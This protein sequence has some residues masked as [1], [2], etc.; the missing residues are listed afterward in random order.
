MAMAVLALFFNPACPIFPVVGWIWLMNGGV[1][2]LHG[3]Q[4]IGE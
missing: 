1:P 4:S 3:S 2:G